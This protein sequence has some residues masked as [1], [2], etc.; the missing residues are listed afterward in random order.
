MVSAASFVCCILFPKFIFPDDRR[1]LV[2]IAVKNAVLAGFGHI[3]LLDLDTIDLS[4]LNRQFLFRKKDVK[5]SKAMVCPLP[6]PCYHCLV[7]LPQRVSLQ[8][9][10]RTASAFN[11]NVHIVPI[12]GNIKDTQFD[13]AWF[14]GFDIVLNA[15]DNLGMPY[16]F[17]AV[18]LETHACL[19]DARR[20]VNKM[21]MAGRIPLVESGTAGY[22]GQVQP[23][24][25]VCTI[26]WSLKRSGPN[27]ARPG[28]YRMFR[29]HP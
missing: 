11:P 28:S 12:H 18:K 3:T 14:Q 15:L 16:M 27:F 8:V 23:L 22:L 29:L 9:A 20:H 1:L 10:A 2:L 17:I 25:K 5:Q 21:C 26:R 4:N 7:T 24:L 19:S 13:L 6:S